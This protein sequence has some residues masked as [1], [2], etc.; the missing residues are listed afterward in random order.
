[1]ELTLRAPAL[2]PPPSARPP[3]LGLTPR[4]IAGLHEELSAYH[5]EFA[6]LFR[7][8]EQRRWALK[9]TAGPLL[10]QERTSIVPLADMQAMQQCIGVGAWDDEAVLRRHQALVAET[11][12]DARDRARFP[13]IIRHARRDGIGVGTALWALVAMGHIH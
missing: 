4:E 11:L 6:S 12:G 8:A 1:M 2:P 13:D 7:R 9:Y 3:L 10:P 5:R